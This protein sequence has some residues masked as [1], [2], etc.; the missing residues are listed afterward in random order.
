M[1]KEITGYKAYARSEA[2]R[3]APVHGLNRPLFHIDL[4][5]ALQSA[6]ANI[7]ATSSQGTVKRGVG[8]DE[9]SNE[10]LA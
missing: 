7:E 4:T 2:K 5:S 10:K 1:N 8:T 6:V 3:V 9:V